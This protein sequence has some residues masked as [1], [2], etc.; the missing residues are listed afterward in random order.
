MT[1]SR[2]GAALAAAVLCTA[3]LI[4][5]S[6]LTGG[7]TTARV[8]AARPTLFAGIPQRGNV[9]GSPH[10]PLTLVEYADLQCPYCGA[11]ARETL[12]ALVSEYVRSGQVRLVFRGM[13]F[14]GPESLTALRA[15]VAAGRQDRLWDFA[16]AIYASQGAENTGWVTDS[17]LRALATAIPALDADRLLGDAGS[18]SVTRDLIALEHVAHADGITGT[19]SFRLGRTGGRLLPLEITSLDISAFRPAIDRLL[20]A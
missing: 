11:F 14:V 17:Y 8:P 16:H 15:V 19:P 13:A 7:T 5:A 20:G 9:L 18:A 2:Y 6:Q 1:R 3:A 4:A 10:A 12:P